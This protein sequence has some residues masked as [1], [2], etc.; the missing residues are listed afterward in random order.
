[1]IWKSLRHPNILELYGASNTN[2]GPP[3]FFV[4]PYMKNGNLSDYLKRLVWSM[5]SEEPMGLQGSG[6]VNILKMM[7]DIAKGMEYLHEN[8]ILHGDLKVGVYLF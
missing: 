4:T 3:W 7:K 1:M 2:S 8:D 6:T 5:D